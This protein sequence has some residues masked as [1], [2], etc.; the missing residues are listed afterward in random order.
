MKI[1]QKNHGDCGTKLY[2]SWRG[3]KQRCYDNSQKKYNK[4]YKDITV[5][6]EW[7]RYLPFKEWALKN[8]YKEGLTIERI[9]PKGN[10]EPNNCEWITKSENSKRR[11]L[12]YDYSKRKITGRAIE[13]ANGDVLRIKEYCKLKGLVFNTFRVKLNGC[14]MVIKEIDLDCEKSDRVIWTY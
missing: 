11:N 13:M 4:G 6:E 1:R 12:T 2:N 3:M 5:C 7:L 10:Y 14:P 9:N 8:N